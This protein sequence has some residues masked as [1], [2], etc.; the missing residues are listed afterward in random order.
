MKITNRNGLFIPMQIFVPT[1]LSTIE[2][3]LE[4]VCFLDQLSRRLVNHVEVSKPK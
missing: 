3:S 2:H 1:N 4:P